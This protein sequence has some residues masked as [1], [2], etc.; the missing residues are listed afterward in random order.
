[1]W[2][3]QL[4]QHD[5]WVWICI[6]KKEFFERRNS[7]LLS[8]VIR[9]SNFVF[10]LIIVMSSLRRNELSENM[11]RNLLTACTN[12]EIHGTYYQVIEI[13]DAFISESVRGAIARKHNT[14]IIRGF[15]LWESKL[16]EIPASI[17]R[18]NREICQSNRAA[19][20]GK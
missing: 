18:A 4:H 6:R 13:S 19:N 5:R 9:F 11:Y 14:D 12:L 10:W 8:C 17:R 20:C 3:K 7:P 16:H 2:I 15:L 1:M